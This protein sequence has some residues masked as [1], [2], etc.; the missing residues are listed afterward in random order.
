MLAINETYGRVVAPNT[1]QLKRVLPGPIER[2]WAYLTES[3]KRGQWLATG[4][5]DLRVGGELELTWHNDDLSPDKQPTPEHY[6]QFD[7]YTM[8]GH[9]TRCEP[10]R[11][12]AYNWGD[13]GKDAEVMFELTPQ[14][15]DVLLVLTHSHLATRGDMR[16]VSSGWHAHLRILM[17]WL[18]NHIPKPFW[19]MCEQVGQEY[20][21]LIPGD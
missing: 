8:R 10:P 14:G 12:L 2:V 6:Q 16:S 4:E 5:M 11:V 7:G 13:T 17:D 15:D 9:I 20:A 18:D 19:N 21:R 1:V 3:D